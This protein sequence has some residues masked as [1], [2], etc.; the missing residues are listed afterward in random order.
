MPTG[1]VNLTDYYDRFVEA[2]VNSGRFS[3]A[4]EVVRAGL[5]LLD[6]QAREDNQ[7]LALLRSLA[8]EAFDELDHGKAAA[9]DSRAQLAEFI[10]Q[11]GR[12]AAGAPE[13]RP[14]GD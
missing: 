3:N 7:R 1:N 14:A 5:R 4:S 10:G 11:I 9:L 2:L 8:S 13:H 6:Q 12:R